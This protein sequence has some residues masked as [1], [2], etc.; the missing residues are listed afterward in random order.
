MAE[1]TCPTLND[2]TNA[3]RCAENIGGMSNLV[4]IGVKSDLKAEIAATDNL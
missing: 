2:F 3:D 4:Y 1:V